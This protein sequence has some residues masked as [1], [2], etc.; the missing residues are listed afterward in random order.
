LIEA[1]K[2]LYNWATSTKPNDF[3]PLPHH[4]ELG[5]EMVMSPTK[6]FFSTTHKVSI[7]EAVG[8]IIAEMVSPYPPGIPRLLPGERITQAHV[9]YLQKGRDAGMLALDPSD[10]ELKKLR[11][12]KLSDRK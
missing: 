12:V 7:T 5:T 3:V 4:R 9:D 11:V 10:Q 8:E 2:G 1:V 6:A